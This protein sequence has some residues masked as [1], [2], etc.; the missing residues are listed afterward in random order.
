MLGIID[1]RDKNSYRNGI[2][3]LR[4]WLKKGKSISEE[5]II[6]DGNIPNKKITLFFDNLTGTYTLRSIQINEDEKR[7]IAYNYVISNKTLYG[8]FSDIVNKGINFPDFNACKSIIINIIFDSARFEYFF[9]YIEKHIRLQ[10]IR[11]IPIEFYNFSFRD[12]AHIREFN[13][14]KL[15]EGL[16]ILDAERYYFSNKFTGNKNDALKTI[17]F[18]KSL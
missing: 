8:A 12:Y 10:D 16:T 17:R 4:E 6:I 11:N 5:I 15:Y 9:N 1:I 2:K 13:N 3:K 18:F 14:K 7:E